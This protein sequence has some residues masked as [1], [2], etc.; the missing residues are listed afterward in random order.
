MTM[1]IRLSL[2][3]SRK[4]VNPM[5]FYSVDD[6]SLNPVRCTTDARLMIVGNAQEVSS[7]VMKMWILE[8]WCEAK[9]RVQRIMSQNWNKDYW[10]LN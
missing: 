3:Q 4:H 10:E 1:L 7:H 9:T 6:V 8:K 5:Y 2:Y